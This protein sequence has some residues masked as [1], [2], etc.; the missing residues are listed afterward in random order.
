MYLVVEL[1]YS[2]IF[3]TQKLFN[4]TELKVQLCISKST[5]RELKPTMPDD[6]ERIQK[7]NPNSS[8]Y[9]AQVYYET[10]Q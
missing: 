10:W 9:S 7:F 1:W 5:E 2:N 4:E 6:E 8:L 3:P